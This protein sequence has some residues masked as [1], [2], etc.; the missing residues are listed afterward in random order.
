MK[1]GV[2]AFAVVLM[3]TACV[4]GNGET[5][6]TNARISAPTIATTTLGST[7]PPQPSTTS[8]NETLTPG[9]EVERRTPNELL[10]LIPDDP[11]YRSNV[12]IIDYEMT[13]QVIGSARSSPGGP[14]EDYWLDDSGPLDPG[15]FFSH[16]ISGS[17]L[18]VF[19]EEF[20]LEI[21]EVEQEILVGEFGE[22]ISVLVGH[23]DPNH[24]D[25]T[26]KNHRTWGELVEVSSSDGIV[27]YDWGTRNLVSEASPARPSGRAGVLVSDV[28]EEP[29]VLVRAR[30]MGE[31]Q[32]FV[33][34]LAGGGASLSEVPQFSELA[35]RLADVGASTIFLSDTP[36]R[37]TEGIVRSQLDNVYLSPYT[38]IGLGRLTTE[39]GWVSALVLAHADTEAAAEN[40]LRIQLQIENGGGFGGP[41]IDLFSV[42]SLELDGTYLIV[43]LGSPDQRDSWRRLLF[44][45]RDASALFQIDDRTG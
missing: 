21:S 16:V 25:S 3:A 13:E 40:A 27:I 30:T 14:L 17:D 4:S 42:L 5:P 34:L 44:E 7:S 32:P 23:W 8:A 31:V 24:V 38:H 37:R 18:E 11:E 19:E 20:G 33:D 6:T 26:I 12:W 1:S 28:S 41:L 35:R 15:W 45:W 29:L 9:V 2:A 43:T 36:P 22:E 10:A 39:N